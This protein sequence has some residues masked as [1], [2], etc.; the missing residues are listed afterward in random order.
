VALLQASR[1]QGRGGSRQLERAQDAT[2]DRSVGDSGDD[3]QGTL[4]TTR[5]AQGGALAFITKARTN[6]TDLL[7][8]TLTKVNALLHRARQN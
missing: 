5:T 2:D 4:V 3:P 1:G 7:T 6:P 8:G